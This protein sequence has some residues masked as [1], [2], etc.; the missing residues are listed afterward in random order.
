[1]AST[2]TAVLRIIRSKVRLLIAICVALAVG[3]LAPAVGANH[4]I[5]RWLLAWNCGALLYVF[6]AAVMMARSTPHSMRR[7]A[8]QQDEGQAV[9]LTFVVVSTVASLA[10]IAGDLALVKELHG[11]L[12][13]AHIALA[14]LTVLSSWA[15]V[16]VMFTLHYAH[17]YYGNLARG[18]ASAQPPGLQ[19]P[20]D[21]PPD[22]FD[23][24]YFAAVI[25]TSG[26]T[27]DVAFVSKSMRRL[28]TLHCILAYLFNT[29]VLALL[30]NIGASVI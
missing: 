8:Q 2:Q 15:F 6:L 25:G 26:Q 14:G 11:F 24:F 22:Y 9:I 17:G 20:G 10:A 27:A 21:E 23:F 29:L 3:L 5:T 16:Q 1:M 13:A 18:E 7:R 30:I 28:G 19:F 12:K 4:A